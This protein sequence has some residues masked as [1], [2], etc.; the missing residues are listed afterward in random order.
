[1]AKNYDDY[2]EGWNAAKMFFQLQTASL[3]RYMHHTDMRKPHEISC[4][5]DKNK[6]GNWV[7]ID[8]VTELFEETAQ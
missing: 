6:D 1:M 4:G 5:M 3:Q 8:D 7:R 2:M